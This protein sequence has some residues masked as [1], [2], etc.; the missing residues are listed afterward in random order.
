[1]LNNSKQYLIGLGLKELLLDKLTAEQLDDLASYAMEV[2]QQ[3]N[4]QQ[5]LIQLAAMESRGKVGAIKLVE[6]QIVS[7]SQLKN[8][9]NED[10]K[11]VIEVFET[12]GDE[13]VAQKEALELIVVGQQEKLFNFTGGAKGEF[14]VNRDEEKP[15]KALY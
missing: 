10:V 8:L 7:I 4:L 15:K 12:S 13:D 3:P 11:H 2:S 1:M 5:N 6:K 14:Y 9:S